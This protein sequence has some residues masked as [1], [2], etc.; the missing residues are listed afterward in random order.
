MSTDDVVAAILASATTAIIYTVG[1]VAMVR[2]VKW[3]WFF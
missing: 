1:L 2:I 3:A